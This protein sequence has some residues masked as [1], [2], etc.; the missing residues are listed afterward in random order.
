MLLAALAIF[1]RKDPEQAVKVAGTAVLSGLL[2]GFARYV[3]GHAVIKTV[4]RHGAFARRAINAGLLFWC[5]C[6]NRWPASGRK[7]GARLLR[8][9]SRWW[10]SCARLHWAA[11]PAPTT[12]P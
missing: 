12:R 8:P 1:N 2:S 7:N 10:C 5:I 11:G 3:D 4:N 9:L 6:E